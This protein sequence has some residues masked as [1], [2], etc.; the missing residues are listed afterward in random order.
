MRFAVGP[1]APGELPP[2]SENAGRRLLARRRG[3]VTRLPGATWRYLGLPLIDARWAAAATSSD[4]TMAA[5][6]AGQPS[7]LLR[8]QDG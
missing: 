7:F 4:E 1:L 6:A 3:Q 8:Q 2:D 5:L